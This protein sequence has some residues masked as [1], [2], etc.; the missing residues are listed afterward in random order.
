MPFSSLLVA[1]CLGSA[2]ATLLMAFTANYPYALA[3]GMEHNAFLAFAVVLGMGI[4]WQTALASV[5]IEG[6]IFIVLTLIKLREAI[7]NSIT[8]Y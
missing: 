6:L 2:L 8:K 5:L 7:I 1:T 3:P 4:S